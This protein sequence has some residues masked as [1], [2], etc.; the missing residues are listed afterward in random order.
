MKSNETIPLIGNQNHTRNCKPLHDRP[1]ARH[2]S[3]SGNSSWTFSLVNCNV[4]RT[5]SRVCIYLLDYD[6]FLTMINGFRLSRFKS[7]FDTKE[8]VSTVLMTGLVFNKIANRYIR[9]L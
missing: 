4:K 1:K 8:E 2:M 3:F 7:S 9:N 5:L 6:F